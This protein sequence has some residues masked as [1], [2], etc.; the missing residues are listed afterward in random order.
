MDEKGLTFVTMRVLMSII[1]AG[2]IAGLT[3][4]GLQY[5]LKIEAEKQ[6]E[7]EC[8]DLISRISAM[9]AGGS[10]RY[11]FDANAPA[12]DKRIAEI[13]LPDNIVYLSFGFD[14]DDKTSMLTS[15]GSCIFYKI[16]GRSKRVIWLDKSIKFRKGINISGKWGIKEPEQGFVITEG[17]KYKITFELVEDINKTKFVLIEY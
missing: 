4:V 8:N 3:F 14:P 15:N 13:Y 9:V 10:A 2:I 7:R 12:G 5:A 17:G 1:I 16:E 6:I 11:L